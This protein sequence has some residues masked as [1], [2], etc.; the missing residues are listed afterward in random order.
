MFKIHVYKNYV[1]ASQK[2]F[3]VISETVQSNHPVTLGLATGSSPIGMYA[4][5]VE[6]HLH[7]GTSYRH[8]TTYNL[9]EYVGLPIGHPQSYLTFMNEHLFNH[10]DCPR[11]Q[12]HM[13]SVNSAHLEAEA[14]KYSDAVLKAQIDIQVL[15]VGSNGHIGFN[16]P[17]TPFDSIT[18]LVTLKEGT[19]IDNARFFHDLNEVP[20]YAVSM[21]ITEILS[22]KKIMLIAL[23]KN[24]ASVV[25]EM[26]KGVIREE[27][28]CTILQKHPNVVLILDEE[29]ASL[30]SD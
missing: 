28:P 13:P 21:G 24:K 14:K 11:D 6:D 19:R 8:V 22:A 10:I 15:G 30:L 3:E 23:G 20:Q 1:E 18:H 7:N 9:D 5:M 26:V 25:K 4:C 12:I 29:A 17:G 2:A 16:E 27:V